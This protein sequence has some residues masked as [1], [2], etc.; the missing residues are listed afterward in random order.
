MRHLTLK[1]TEYALNMLALLGISVI[2][3]MAFAFQFFWY[4]LPCPLCLLQR[5]GFLLMG[6]GFL[7]NLRF[8]LHPVHYT[9]VLLSAVYTG[10][11]ALRQILLHIIPGTGDYGSA[12]FGLHMYTWSFIFVVLVIIATAVI[13]GASRQYETH[14]HFFAAYKKTCLLLIS[15][16]FLIAVSNIASV[17]A[18]CAWR[19]CPDNPV[20]YVH[21]L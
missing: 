4:E 5:V 12:I 13:L 2:L 20:T 14:S 17:W 8:G 11:V 10:F 19:A 18:E 7:M 16:F 6:I 21:T 15:L 9:L 3:L 1:Q